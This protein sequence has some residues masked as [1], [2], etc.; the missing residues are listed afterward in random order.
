MKNIKYLVVSG[1]ALS[2]LSGCA[3]FKKKTL[4]APCGPTAGVTDPCGN[5]TP[6]N[7]D[8]R[9]AQGLTLEQIFSSAVV[10]I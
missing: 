6:L 10:D 5:R 3:T 1:I 7:K 2:M 8:F 9:D 4:K